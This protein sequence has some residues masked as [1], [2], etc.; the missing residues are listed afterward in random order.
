VRIDYPTG[1]YVVDTEE[2]R[3]GSPSRSAHK[4]LFG[5]FW[6]E[7][8]FFGVLVARDHVKSE[9]DPRLVVEPGHIEFIDM[10]DE[11]VEVSF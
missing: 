10:R 6:P 5:R 9:H 3:L 4:T 8:G 11:M 2:G 1:L 7:E